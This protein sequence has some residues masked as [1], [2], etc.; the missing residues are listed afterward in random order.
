MD[1]PTLQ[2]QIDAANAY[3]ALF[4]PALFG[5][6][7]RI[8]VDAARIHPG[9]RVLDVACGTGILA[10]EICSRLGASARVTAVDP[11]PGMIAVARQLAPAVECREGVA[12]SL[13]LPDRSFDVVVSQ[14]GL[15][16]FSDRQQ[17]LREM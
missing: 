5:Q 8:V 15:M 2:D 3:E 13:P 16:F 1:Q 4:V 14:F 6:W 11:N 12:E 7:A 10:R 17:A 9:Q